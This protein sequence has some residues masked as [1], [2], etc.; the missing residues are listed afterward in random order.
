MIVPGSFQFTRANGT[1]SVV[2][3]AWNMGTTLPTSGGPCCRSTVRQSQPAWAITSAENELGTCSHPLRT[4]PPFLQIDLTLFSRTPSP[5]ELPKTTPR[6]CGTVIL[7]RTGPSR[8][9]GCRPRAGT[10][11]GLG[12]KLARIG[13]GAGGKGG[14]VGG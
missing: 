3:M 13:G 14:V 9:R 7:C 6:R 8:C 2:E 10:G 12:G 11:R 5:P 1:T 4:T